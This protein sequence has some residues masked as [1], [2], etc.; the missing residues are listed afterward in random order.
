MG[1]LST[2]LSYARPMAGAS[3]ALIVLEKQKTL[4]SL[5]SP[6]ACAQARSKL[7]LHAVQIAMR[8]TTSLCALRRSSAAMRYT[9]EHRGAN[10]LGWLRE[11]MIEQIVLRFIDFA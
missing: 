2:L 11:I 3:C 4:P 6:L 9:Q 5:I 10:L 8:N 1:N 7:V